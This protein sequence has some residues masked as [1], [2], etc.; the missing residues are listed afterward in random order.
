ML[1]RPLLPLSLFQCEVCQLLGF[2]Y[3]VIITKNNQQV[4][5]IWNAVIH[6]HEI[7][8]T[9]SFLNMVP[10]E[11][12]FQNLIDQVHILL[13]SL[14]YQ[15][16]HHPTSSLFLTQPSSNRAIT[17]EQK[18]VG[19]GKCPCSFMLSNAVL[20]SAGS[21]FFKKLSTSN[22]YESA[23]HTY[24]VVV[25]YPSSTT[26]LHQSPK[27]SLSYWSPIMV[28]LSLLNYLEEVEHEFGW[29]E[30]RRTTR[31]RGWPK[32]EMRAAI[33]LEV[34]GPWLSEKALEEGDRN[35][36]VGV[37]EAG[38]PWPLD[39][40]CWKRM[41]VLV[42]PEEANHKIPCMG[43]AAP[44]WTELNQVDRRFCSCCL[45]PLLLFGAG[46]AAQCVPKLQQFLDQRRVRSLGI[47]SHK[48]I[49][50]TQR[51]QIPLAYA[52]DIIGI[53]GRNI[54]YMRRTS[55]ASITIE[56]SRGMADEITVEIKGTS[57]EVHIAR[58][59]IQDFVASRT[60]PLSNSYSGLD[61]GS[62][63]SYSHLSSAPYPSSSQAYDRYG[64]SELGSYG[65]Y[66]I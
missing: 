23:S 44:R 49:S 10:H 1:L 42:R 7:D 34:G 35:I 50:V 9:K 4:I 30:L 61:T 20:A 39:K 51:M 48:S 25:I 33:V 40:A 66:R 59:L 27:E 62:G 31:T 41:E 26:L 38:G 63:S 8:S 52:E 13:H 56:E 60:E 3:I 2:G 47:Q 46:P 21:F 17:T 58:Q 55:G 28:E 11:K 19:L 6:C 45:E 5:D 43:A 16:L 14:L 37:I 22:T 65:G 29:L 12:C 32:V 53:G 64:S 36:W 18:K 57:S 15:T 24:Q 54:A